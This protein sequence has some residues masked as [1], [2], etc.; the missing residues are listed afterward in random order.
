MTKGPISSP[1]DESITL[2]L[3]LR[4]RLRVDPEASLMPVLE[5]RLRPD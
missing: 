3:R 4:L 2:I 1:K 5:A